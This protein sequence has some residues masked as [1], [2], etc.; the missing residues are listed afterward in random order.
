[1][2]RFSTLLFQ[3]ARPRH[4]GDRPVK[5]RFNL[6]MFLWLSVTTRKLIIEHNRGKS[7]CIVKAEQQDTGLCPHGRDAAV[8]V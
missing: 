8:H 2:C 1:M 7:R 3:L 6:L 4:P 5:K